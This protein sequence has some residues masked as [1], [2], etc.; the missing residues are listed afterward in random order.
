[1]MC[2]GIYESRNGTNIKLLDDTFFSFSSHQ[3]STNYVISSLFDSLL[4]NN[5]LLYLLPDGKYITAF[6]S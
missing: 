5:N 6:R 3:I 4:C 2:A 1:M